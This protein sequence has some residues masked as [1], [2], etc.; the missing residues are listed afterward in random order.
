MNLH[1]FCLFVTKVLDNTCQAWYNEKVRFSISL[2][3]WCTASKPPSR[4]LTQRSAA[5]VDAYLHTYLDRFRSVQ[6]L[7]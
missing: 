3:T 6:V 4:K 5:S 2:A 1:L 7:P